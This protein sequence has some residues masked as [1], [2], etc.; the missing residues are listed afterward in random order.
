MDSVA[1]AVRSQADGNSVSHVTCF[2]GF[3]GGLR[4]PLLGCRGPIGILRPHFFAQ[5]AQQV[6]GHQ[7]SNRQGRRSSICPQ[8]KPVTGRHRCQNPA[9][10][11]CR[12]HLPPCSLSSPPMSRTPPSC[13]CNRSTPY[14][15]SPCVAPP[16]LQSCFL[17][18]NWGSNH[19]QPLCNSCLCPPPP[20]RHRCPAP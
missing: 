6:A 17:P 13:L 5:P 11:V 4:A 12:R 20:P 19:S 9:Q 16:P 18:C 15:A 10:G 8:Q 2:K 3:L 14:M 1:A 7:E